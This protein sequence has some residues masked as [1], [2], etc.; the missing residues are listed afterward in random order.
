MLLHIRYFIADIILTAD[1]ILCTQNTRCEQYK[2][3]P[4]SLFFSLTAF[5]LET[6]NLI[7]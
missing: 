7:V 5:L 2:A 6:H 4:F 1:C 3:F